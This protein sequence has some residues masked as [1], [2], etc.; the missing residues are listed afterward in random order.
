[1]SGDTQLVIAGNLTDDPALKYTASGVAIA[2]FTVASTPRSFDKTTNAWKDGETLFM[3]CSVWRNQA[4]SVAESLTRGTRVVVTGRL[5]QHSYEDR[6]GNK[7]TVINL[8]VDEVAASLKNATVKVNK[9]SRSSS[10]SG[11]GGGGSAAT[12]DPWG[13]APAS[14]DDAEP[15][16]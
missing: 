5:K 6:E 15:P 1:M 8:D 2:E 7:R 4:E 10:G 14:G 16:F 11:F 9:V 13:S 3:R 12:E